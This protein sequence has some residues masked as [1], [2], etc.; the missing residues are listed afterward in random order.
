M[1]N[2]ALDFDGT[3]T[4]HPRFM[5]LFCHLARLLGFD[6]RIVTVRSEED[7]KIKK[8]YTLGIPV[9]YCNGRPKIEV[10]REVGFIPDFWVDDNPQAVHEGS[11]F[12][13]EMLVEW[14]EKDPYRSKP[15]RLSYLNIGYSIDI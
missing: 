3:Y 15:K 11:A 4:R 2:I 13:E 8:K 10:C 1:T 6:I 7:D 9:I 14:R 5:F 12:T